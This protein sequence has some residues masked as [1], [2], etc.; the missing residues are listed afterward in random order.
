M[1][2]IFLCS[3]VILSSCQSVVESIKLDHAA[4]MLS[5]GQSGQ[6]KAVDER[7]GKTIKVK[8]SS[9]H[10][11][12]ATIDKNGRV[13]AVSRGDAAITAVMTQTGATAT[14]LVSVDV[15]IQNPILPPSW[16][17]YIADPEPKVSGKG[18]Y[19][20]GSRDV[21]DGVL[22]SGTAWCSDRYN[23]LYSEDLVHWADKGVS[24]HL[25]SVPDEYMHPDYKRLWAPDVLKHPTNG[26]YYLYLC[27]NVTPSVR[28]EIIMVAVSDHPEGP[29][30][31]PK[32]LL[33]DGRETVQAIDPGI[34][35]DDDG[36][37][38]VTWP[39]TMGQLDPDDFMNIRG[40]T[41]V[42]MKQWMPQNAPPPFEGPSLRKKG[43]TYYYIYIENDDLIS[44]PD[45]SHHFRPTRMVYMTSQHPL[46][47][48]T[49]KGLIIANTDYPV[50]MSNIHGSLL[51]F[52]DDWH[53]FYHMPVRDK[54]YTRV[55]C[56]E[57]L[58]FDSNGD[59]IP[60]APSSS[61][62][63]GAFHFGDR[64]QASGAVIYPGGE[65]N[66][67]YVSRPKDYGKL[68]FSIPGSYAG[69]RYFDPQEDEAEELVLFVRTHDEGGVFELS[70]DDPHGEIVAEVELPDTRGEW[71]EIHA[72]IGKFRPGKHT[73]YM[74][75][76]DNPGNRNVA[77]DWFMF[78]KK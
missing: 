52:E 5:S 14:C 20:Y 24:F 72:Q 70:I 11:D 73:F 10:P 30:L 15:S 48:Y 1:M 43:D 60:V 13:Q 21:E 55:M 67:M 75:L 9:D 22:P 19:V 42:D 65:L 74:L 35:T 3:A 61:G 76:K 51:E 25:D 4:F 58:Y 56:A 45:G 57:P 39:F 36:K 26:K 29:F 44:R 46:G 38:Y 33:I 27:F 62:I 23:V 32:P 64:I 77:L 66:P 40:E 2:F 78:R 7:T 8:W 50:K 53:V 18:V 16:E 69:Y 6:L 59:I 47:P 49:Y 17:L 71:Q 68:V 31:N 63:K 12:V 37:A 41:V 54:S 34:M 28:E